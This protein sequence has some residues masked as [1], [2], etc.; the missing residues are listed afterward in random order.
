[1]AKIASIDE[2]LET[3]P[4]GFAEIGAQLRGLLDAELPAASGQLWHGHPV[5]MEGKT[6]V[7]GFKAYANW[8][9]FMLWDG[10]KI[11]DF[12]GRLQPNSRDMA[13]VKLTGLDDIDVP[14]FTEWL[15]VA[16]DL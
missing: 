1:M 12:S 15:D 3:M 13:S 6:P 8:V 14:L 16:K 10:Q 11:N 9:T 5:W 4:D 2:Y 7:A